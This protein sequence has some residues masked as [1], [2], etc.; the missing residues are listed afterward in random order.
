MFVYTC[1]LSKTH[2]HAH[3]QLDWDEYHVHKKILCVICVCH[4]ASNPDL[5][6]PHSE[7]V[8]VRTRVAR[9]RPVLDP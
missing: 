7:F 2:T 9:T 5:A 6:L 3:S 4:C 8:E 1:T